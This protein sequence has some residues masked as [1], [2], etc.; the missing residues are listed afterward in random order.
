M[1][2]VIN[3]L[4]NVAI[5][6]DQLANALLGGDPDMTISARMGRAIRNGRCHLCRPIC[7]LLDRIDP[8]HCSRAD[9]AERDEGRAQIA[10]Y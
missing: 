2:K 6:I 1:R 5:S 4:A 10:R 9:R 8:G 7:W 3:Y